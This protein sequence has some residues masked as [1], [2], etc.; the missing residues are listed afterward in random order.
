LKAKV[1]VVHPV[2]CAALSLGDAGVTIS[3]PFGFRSDIVGLTRYGCSPSPKKAR[4]WRTD[5]H[6]H[7]LAYHEM[8]VTVDATYY[9]I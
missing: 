9:R 3:I 5:F 2:T 6:I 4:H 1:A 7:P 8:G